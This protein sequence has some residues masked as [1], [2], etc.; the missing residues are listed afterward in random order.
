MQHV[1]CQIR[2]TTGLGAKNN[3]AVVHQKQNSIA[4]QKEGSKNLEKI[5]ISTLQAGISFLCQ[6]KNL[7]IA[8]IKTF[9]RKK[10]IKF[11]DMFLNVVIASK[12]LCIQKVPQLI[13]L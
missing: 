13:T 1:T 6:Y 5:K 12:K 8:R 10:H 7:F 2:I 9:Y 4:K 3:N 11:T